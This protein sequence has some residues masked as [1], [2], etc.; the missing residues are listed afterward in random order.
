MSSTDDLESRISVHNQPKHHEDVEKKMD[1]VKIVCWDDTDPAHPRN[2]PVKR[3]E[4]V[5]CSTC[6]RLSVS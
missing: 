2:M 3:S 1:V 6:H 4:I 5:Q